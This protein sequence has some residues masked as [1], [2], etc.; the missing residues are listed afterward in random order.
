MKFGF[1]TRRTSLFL[2]R[3]IALTSLQK[4]RSVPVSSYANNNTKISGGMTK[5]PVNC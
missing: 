2:S 1:F 4:I 5:A 3:A